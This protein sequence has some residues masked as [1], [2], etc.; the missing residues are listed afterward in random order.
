MDEGPGGDG[1]GRD[2][3]VEAAPVDPRWPSRT[4]GALSIATAMRAR[5]RTSCEH[6]IW[7]P[8]RSALG[9]C[10]FNEHLY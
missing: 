10:G 7:R 9:S 3:R 2:G 1:L 5:V 8:L 6:H 4:A